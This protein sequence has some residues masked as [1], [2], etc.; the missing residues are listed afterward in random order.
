MIVK[1]NQILKSGPKFVGDF[2]TT[3]ELPAVG[4]TFWY[5]THGPYTVVGRTFIYK[6][7]RDND[8]PE[9]V[10]LDVEELSKHV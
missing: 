6:R 10:I 8:R 2:E 7:G 1:V 5:D 4:D 9:D 3:Q